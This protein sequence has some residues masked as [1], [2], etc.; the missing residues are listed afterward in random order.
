[1]C[2]PTVS[3]RKEPVHEGK[4]KCALVGEWQLHQH[5]GFVKIYLSQGG[6]QTLS[7]PLLG[8]ANRPLLEQTTH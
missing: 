3:G 5:S 6:H 4:P 8:R 2:W 7:V 1:M